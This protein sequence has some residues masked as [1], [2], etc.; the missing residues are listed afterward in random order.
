MELEEYYPVN[1]ILYHHLLKMEWI[2]NAIL[3]FVSSSRMIW[4]GMDVLPNTSGSMLMLDGTE[5]PSYDNY[6]IILMER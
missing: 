6:D 5:L 3:I 2:C 4:D 1:W